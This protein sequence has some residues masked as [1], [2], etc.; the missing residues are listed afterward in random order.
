[1]SKA[2]CL[3]ISY[4]FAAPSSCS[5]GS[6]LIVCNIKSSTL[7]RR[8]YARYHNAPVMFNTH[9][10]LESA[11]ISTRTCMR[12]D[13]DPALMGALHATLGSV[14]P[15]YDQRGGVYTLP[16]VELPQRFLTNNVAFELRC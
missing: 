1:M 9:N 4:E 16:E 13:H 8:Y 3:R 5:I 6:E 15:N 7:G 12:S 10:Y 11:S 2:K 14:W